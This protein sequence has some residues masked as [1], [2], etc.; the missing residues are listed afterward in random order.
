M[1]RIFNRLPSVQ[2]KGKRLFLKKTVHREKYLVVFKTDQ[3]STEVGDYV[4]AANGKVLWSGGG[5][6][7]R[8]PEQM[9]V[10]STK[11]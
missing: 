4:V 2:T 9:L 5:F 7:E 1:F 3:F 11:V 6:I 10:K 8:P